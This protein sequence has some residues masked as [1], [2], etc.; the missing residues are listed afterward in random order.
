M[1]SRWRLRP[2]VNGAMIIGTLGISDGR[3]ESLSLDWSNNWLTVCGPMLPEQGLRVHYLEAVCRAN[4]READ[5]VTHTLI[6]HRTDLVRRTAD[7]FEVQLITFVEDGLQMY[8]RIRAGND[9]VDFLVEAVHTGLE[10][11][12][13]EWAQVCPRLGPFTG[14]S[15]AGPDLND[16]L[17]NCF[18]VLD[19]TLAHLP[20]AQWAT[21]ARYT[22]G[23]V[24]RPRHVPPNDVNPRPLNPRTPDAGL[25]GCF[26]ADRRT[27][28]ATAWEPYQELFQGV[29]RCLHADFRIGGLMP[30]QRRTIRGKMYLMP[31]DPSRLLQRYRADFP[32]HVETAR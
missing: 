7:G 13:A 12:V 18:I 10:R 28:W 16:Y 15:D 24:W 19:G 20:T 31:A 11:S 26:S 1:V 8:H 32:E 5:W 3:A 6:P 4:S 21:Q 29:A 23:Q 9:E 2:I 27:I 17:P 30:R 22:P 14:Y 25:I